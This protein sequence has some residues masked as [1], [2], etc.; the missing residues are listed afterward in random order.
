MVATAVATTMPTIIPTR[1]ARRIPWALASLGWGA[2]DPPGVAISFEDELGRGRGE[3]SA[4]SVD[5]TDET[6]AGV[7]KDTVAFTSG[8]AVETPEL[9]E[10]LIAPESM[11]PRRELNDDVAMVAAEEGDGGR[12]AGGFASPPV[13][14]DSAA[15]DELWTLPPPSS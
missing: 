12:V 15:D 7:G 14:S 5:A 10:G 13:G 6:P 8:L 9:V 1:P 4:G 11:P 2:S 3:D